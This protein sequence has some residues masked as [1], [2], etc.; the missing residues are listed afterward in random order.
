LNV[1]SDNLLS[2]DI[3]LYEAL[4][5]YKQNS[6]AGGAFQNVGITFPDIRLDSVSWK[7]EVGFSNSSL[8]MD[9]SDNYIYDTT[10]VVRVSCKQADYIAAKTGLDFLTKK[11]LAIVHNDP[12]LSTRAPRMESDNIE[13]GSV[14]DIK[15]R[16]LTFTFKE[17]YGVEYTDEDELVITDLLFDLEEE[18]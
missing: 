16:I 4:Q 8:N 9:S 10:V 7:I 3:L 5:N 15:S 12:V 2:S 1:L 13:L 14:Y 11:I 18:D 6:E 17:D